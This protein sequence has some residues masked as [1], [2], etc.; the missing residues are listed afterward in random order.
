MSLNLS[1]NAQKIQ[2]TLAGFGLDLEVVELSES[3]RTAKE[4]AHAI[5]CTVDQIAKSLVFKGKSSQKPIMVVA[6]G[7]N[8]VNEKAFEKYIG[9]PL[10]KAD[11]NFV[12]KETGFSIGGVA[13]IALENPMV[14]FID[15]DLMTFEEIWAAAG[16]PN[17]VFK[18][19]S[20]DLAKITEGTIVSIK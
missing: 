8:R 16:T 4:A 13:P 9:E 7:P 6:S 14:V 19:S 1:K 12:L 17:S 3:T 18:I 15:Q 2:N 11:A 5:G 20:K 10:E